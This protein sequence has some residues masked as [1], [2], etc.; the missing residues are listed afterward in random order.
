[1]TKRKARGRGGLGGGGGEGGIKYFSKAVFRL[2][3]ARKRWVV[4][5]CFLSQAVM[6]CLNLCRSGHCL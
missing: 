2:L 4:G 1:M 6:S 5:C 3:K